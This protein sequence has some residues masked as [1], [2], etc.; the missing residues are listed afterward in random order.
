MNTSNSTYSHK[1]KQYLQRPK[2]MNE[3]IISKLREIA[4]LLALQNSNHFRINAY[5]HAADIIEQLNK[6]IEDIVYHHGIAGLTALPN[7]GEGIARLLYEYVATGKVTRLDVLKGE[8]DPVSMLISIPGIGKKLANKIYEQL[9]IGSIDELELA[10]HDGRLEKVSEI[11]ESRLK[12]I[13]IWLDNTFVKRKYHPLPQAQNVKPTV[14][15]ILEID[16]KYRTSAS[17]NILP[18]ITPKR[19]NKKNETWLPIM[20]SYQNSWHFTALFSNSYLAH[21]LGKILDWVIIYYYDK[22]HQ[23]GQCTVVTEYRGKL[24]GK[25][26]IRGRELECKEYYSPDQV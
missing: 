3:D 25:R 23:G 15:L 5:N 12:A 19:F 16:K 8:N 21:E 14:A 10:A 17:R 13:K 6:P 7:I 24:K 18:K 20:H 9:H 1:Y 2:R 4:D 26:I 22:S 11:G